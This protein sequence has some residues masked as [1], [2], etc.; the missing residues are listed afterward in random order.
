MK[1][2]I[3]VLAIF[4]FTVSSCEKRKCKEHQEKELQSELLEFQKDVSNPNLTTEQIQEIT[5]RHEAK[6][7]EILAECN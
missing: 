6:Q 5:I 4:A 3:L 7:K 1:R 2:I